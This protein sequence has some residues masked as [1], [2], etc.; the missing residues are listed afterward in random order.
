MAP[1]SRNLFHSNDGW[2]QK[3]GSSKYACHVNIVFLRNSVIIFMIKIFCKILAKTC[4]SLCVKAIPQV[5]VN[6]KN[7]MIETR[8]GIRSFFQRNTS[9]SLQ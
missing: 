1:F 6:K 5:E 7:T 8:A 9:V 3:R 2:T 4:S